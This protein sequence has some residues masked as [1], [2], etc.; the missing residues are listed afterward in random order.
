[1]GLREAERQGTHIVGSPSVDCDS[2]NRGFTRR[3]RKGAGW[4]V[5]SLLIL[6][7]AACG[8][9]DGAV[10]T[11]VA[12]TE[13]PAATTTSP[14][15]VTTSPGTTPAPSAPVALVNATTSG[16]VGADEIWRGEIHLTGDIFLAPGVTLT[17]E[18]GTTVFL[19]SLSDDQGCCIGGGYLDDY[20]RSH[21][22]PTDGDQWTPKAIAIDGRGAAIWA[23]G[24]P[25]QRIVF[26]PEGD[27]SSPA[28]WDGILVD[29]GSI[30]YVDVLYGGHTAIQVVGGASEVEIAHNEVRHYL[31]AGI[32]VHAPG[33]WVHHNVVEGGG[34]QAISARRDSLVEHNV[35]LRS[36]TGIGIESADGVVVRNNI[37][38]D[39][40][41]GI[42]IRSGGNVVVHNNTIARIAGPPDG[43]YFGDQLVYP[44]FEVGGGIENYL[45]FDGAEIINN[46]VYGPFD[47]GI[48]L[49][50]AFGGNPLI[51][52]N[53]LWGQVEGYSGP[54]S[55]SAGA[56]IAVDPAFVDA[57]N[58][59]LRLSEGSPAID[60]GWPDITD[61]NGS[62]SDLGA[63]GGPAAGH[64]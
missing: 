45:T 21:N 34:H 24:T 33:A 22:D 37:I 36:Q 26:R 10:D 48:G 6:V 19:A 12:T 18:P 53:L 25:E 30:Q 51:G 5:L 64:W 28:Q 11:V 49:H 55:P 13:G 3:S 57:P 44:A 60:A 41:R 46:I 63:Y 14:G 35:V 20:T 38:I 1:M 39:S 62:P 54:G 61:A 2:M 32:D 9:D 42:E 47:W 58:G 29:T 56:V 7:A 27:S 16:T 50:H 31:W 43:W 15:A 59:D 52:A 17:I 8:A 4:P 40:A 23:V